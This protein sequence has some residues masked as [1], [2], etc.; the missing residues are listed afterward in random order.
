[1]NPDHQI[2]LLFT[3]QVGYRNKTPIKLID[4]LVNNYK[5]INLNYL[6]ISK[7]AEST[8][9]S[10][11]IKTG[12]LFRSSYVNSHTSDVLRYLSLW[13]YGGT[14]LDLGKLTFH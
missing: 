2:F 5:N 8:P 4:T 11:W 9:L 12:E 7:Y 6:N 13:K 1:M 10:N 3:S 14:Y